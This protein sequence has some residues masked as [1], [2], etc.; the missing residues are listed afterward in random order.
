MKR[1]IWII[2]IAATLLALQ[3]KSVYALWFLCSDF[4]YCILFP[5]LVMALFDKKAN[6]YGSLVGLIVSFVLRFGGGEVT[7]E[8]PQLLPY[9]M[10]ENRV[11]VFP[12]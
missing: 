3:V 8:V 9:P 5:Q 7:L 12:F 4:V 2:G 1:C 10:V 11:V 6:Y